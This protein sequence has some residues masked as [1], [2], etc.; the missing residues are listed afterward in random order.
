MFCGAV[1]HLASNIV[2]AAICELKL[3]RSLDGSGRTLQ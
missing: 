1:L 2:A 3:M